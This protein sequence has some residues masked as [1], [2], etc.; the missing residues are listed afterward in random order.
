M[1]TSK[2]IAYLRTQRLARL[3]TV[4]A[5]GQP[6]ADAVAFEFDGTHFF[7]GGYA[8][9]KTR[10]YKNI[11]SDQH[12]VSLIIDDL[13]AIDPWTPRGIKIHGYAEAVKRPGRFGVTDYLAIRPT[14]SWSWGIEGESFQAGRFTPHRTVWP[15]QPT[16]QEERA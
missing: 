1:F 13:A 7:I 12:L 3:A 2:E 16:G 15:V 4:S 9:A 6:D 8:L 14:I 11:A 5:Q 10:K